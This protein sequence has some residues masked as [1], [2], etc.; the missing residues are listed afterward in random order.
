MR[1]FQLGWSGADTKATFYK[2]M[3]DAELEQKF[4]NLASRGYCVT[5][6][7]S[8]RPNCIGWALG[9][10]SQY[11]D[12]SLVGVRGYY[13]PPGAPKTD[14]V[15]SWVRVFEIHGYRVCEQGALEDGVEKVA[16]YSDASGD[17][18]HVARQLENGR[19]TSKLGKGHD[20]WHATLD[21]LSGK[22]Y[23]DVVRFLQRPRL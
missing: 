13:W 16:I 18:S 2:P 22:D 21:A 10:N 19:W 20:I 11:W 7:E 15:S 8:P 1:P 17:A 3:R 23:G 6:D 9:D 12:P 4:P 14:A 5:S